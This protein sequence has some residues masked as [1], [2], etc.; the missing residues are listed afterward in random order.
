MPN[1]TGVTL[2]SQPTVL[3]PANPAALLRHVLRNVTALMPAFAAG[4]MALVAPL[5][6][7]GLAQGKTIVLP[8]GGH[9]A[10]MCDA[11]PG[12][13]VANCGFETGNFTGWTKTLAPFPGTDL[14][15][16]SGPHSGN[17]A[18]FFGAFEP[19]DEDMISQSI[20]TIPGD[21][22]SISFVLMNQEGTPNQFNAMFGSTD[23]L[24]LT[25]SAPFGFKE[26]TDT[27][28]ATGSSTTLSFAAF[29]VP[30]HFILDDI[31]VL[32]VTPVTAVPEPASLVL[33]GA[34]LFALA[35]TRRRGAA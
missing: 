14:T 1:K 21:A 24:S 5:G 2:S 27:V 10:S 9:S 23:L 15:V 20:P 8:V 3:S 18:A 32:P 33:L 25:D 7:V 4:L 16:Q 30:A 28:V 12:N 22:Y 34:A 6:L 19:P 35:A 31:S 26:F 29:Q 11:I 13:L 17:F